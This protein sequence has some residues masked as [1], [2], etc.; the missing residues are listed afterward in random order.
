MD[1]ISLNELSGKTQFI[2]V[3][4]KFIA[5]YL[6][7]CGDDVKHIKKIEVCDEGS[8]KIHAKINAG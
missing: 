4:A 5:W 1:R 6:G 7:L 2:G 3:E 8:L